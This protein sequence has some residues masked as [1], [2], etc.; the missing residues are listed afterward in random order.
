MHSKRD[1]HGAKHGAQRDCC[2]HSSSIRLIPCKPLRCGIRCLGCHFRELRMAQGGKSYRSQAFNARCREPANRS[3]GE[4]LCSGGCQ[5][6]FTRPLPR[7]GCSCRHRPGMRGRSG[8]FPAGR[9][10]QMHAPRRTLGHD[11]IHVTYG[12]RLVQGNASGPIRR[13][14]TIHAA[15][16]CWFHRHKV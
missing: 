7:I 4:S 12:Q 1:D 16:R 8:R 3:P 6:P 10:Y 9:R 11:W 15:D 5:D 2:Q 14:A 13:L